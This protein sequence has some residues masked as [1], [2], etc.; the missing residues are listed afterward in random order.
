M[1]HSFH[2]ATQTSRADT[3]HPQN[4]K[5]AYESQSED[6]RNTIREFT[7]FCNRFDI[8]SDLLTPEHATDTS[9]VF[10]AK[11]NHHHAAAVAI[12]LMKDED[13]FKK[14]ISA[15]RKTLDP[16]F[17][18]DVIISSEDLKEKWTNDLH[19]LKKWKDF[20]FGIVMPAAQR[21]LS[22]VL[23]KESIDLK[24]GQLIFVSLAKALGHLHKNGLI[25][26]DFN[27]SNVMR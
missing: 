20:R 19:K 24:S 3:T 18:I 7:L 15:L 12:K 22:I 1:T 26:G 25:H 4:G 5:T 16:K 6:I 2:L 23:M 21:D 27:P 13:H 17:I 11:D 9:V 14:E 10:L 8:R